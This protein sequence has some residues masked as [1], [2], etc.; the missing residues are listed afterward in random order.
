MVGQVVHRGEARCR[1][2]EVLVPVYIQKGVARRRLVVGEPPYC[3]TT[4]YDLLAVVLARVG[5][6]TTVGAVG[7][8]RACVGVRALP[9]VVA[10]LV[11]VVADF[12]EFRAR[13]CF[14][15]ACVETDD[16]HGWEGWGLR[17]RWR[18]LR[19]RWRWRR[20]ICGWGNGRG[21]QRRWR[22]RHG[23]VSCYA[24]ARVRFARQRGRQ[25][26]WWRRWRW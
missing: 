1:A 6:P 20:G 24:H 18:R 13:V 8:E 19:W 5:A 11:I 2:D 26:W 17:W 16:S 9:A 4:A 7:A 21:W 23:W 22:R 14:S 25:V 3:A 15:R 10:V 12:L